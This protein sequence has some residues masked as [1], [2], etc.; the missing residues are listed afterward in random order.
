MMCCTDCLWFWIGT[1][2]N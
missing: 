1:G 2:D